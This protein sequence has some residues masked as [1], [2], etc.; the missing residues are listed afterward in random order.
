MGMGQ[1]LN[2]TI[3]LGEHHPLTSYFRA[4]RVPEFYLSIYISIYLSI[5]LPTYDTIWS[6]LVYSIYLYNLT[7]LVYLIYL[8]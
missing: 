5:Y 6:T 3:L 1:N 7:Y 8:I 2:I 4:P